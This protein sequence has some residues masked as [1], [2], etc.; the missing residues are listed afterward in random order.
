LPELSIVAVPL[1]DPLSVTSEFD[2]RFDGE[3]V[4]EIAKVGTLAPAGN[5]STTLRLYRSP[6]GA[7][8]LINTDVPLDGVVLLWH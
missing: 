4:P 2:P 8:S 7:V 3:T 1:A 6:V 5:T